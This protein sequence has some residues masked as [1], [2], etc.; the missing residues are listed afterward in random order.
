MKKNPIKQ[1]QIKIIHIAKSQVGMSEEDYRTALWQQFK[2]KTCKD[3]T[4]VQAEKLLHHFETLGFKRYNW[5]R[6]GNG[7]RPQKKSAPG[8]ARYGTGHCPAR[9]PKDVNWLITS[10]QRVVILELLGELKW[11]FQAFVNWIPKQFK[12]KHPGNKY[13]AS[14]VINRLIAVRKSDLERKKKK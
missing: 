8:S 13:Q 7:A 11:S 10:G 6:K 1:S 12:F 3:L 4:Y 14:Q 5:R 2:E 9:W